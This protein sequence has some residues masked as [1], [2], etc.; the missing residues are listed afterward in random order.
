MAHSTPP[1]PQI[2]CLAAIRPMK[3][4]SR[5]SDKCLSMMC[6]HSESRTFQ[7]LAPT[8]LLPQLAPSS[9]LVPLMAN[10]PNRSSTSARS[11]FPRRRSMST[12]STSPMAL[13]PTPGKC[14]LSSMTTIEGSWITLSST[15][16][17]QSSPFS[18]QTNM[19]RSALT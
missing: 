11:R 18:T 10:G 16:F 3:S 19:A 7:P 15:F 8:R 13:R 4:M 1:C 14:R 2:S 6:P 5:L 9:H 12:S 17:P